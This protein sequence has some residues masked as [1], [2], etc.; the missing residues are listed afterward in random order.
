MN[1]VQN[2]ITSLHTAATLG[3]ARAVDQLL[4]IHRPLVN[5]TNRF[6]HTAL[7]IAAYHNHPQVVRVLL[8]RGADIHI[9]DQCGLTALQLAQEAGH[10]RIVQI[11]AGNWVR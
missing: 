3:D 10:R 2:V 7:H 1:D 9:K 6:G 5:T 8:Q 11:L 4:Q